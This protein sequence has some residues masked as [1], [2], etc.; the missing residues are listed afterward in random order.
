M[1]VE[2]SD[3]EE[4]VVEVLLSTA[5]EVM[6]PINEPPVTISEIEESTNEKVGPIRLED[7]MI[8]GYGTG[9]HHQSGKDVF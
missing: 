9:A 7:D 6:V 3:S 5:C 1:T 8:T 4:S 2:D